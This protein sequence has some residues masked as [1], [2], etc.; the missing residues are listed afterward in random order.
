M[1]P[2]ERLTQ[3]MRRRM[4]ELRIKTWRQLAAHADISYETLRSARTGESVP[5]D[6]TKEGLERALR[7]QHGSIDAVLSGGDPT[8]VG[9]HRSGT[10]SIESKIRITGEGHKA[11][12]ADELD[13]LMEDP[14]AREAIRVLIER[15]R[16][17]H[18]APPLHSGDD[19]S[20]AKDDKAAG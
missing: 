3:A 13:K 20:S 16:A 8:P 2:H 11:E 10:A 4:A 18:G 19:E 9:D 17:L 14:E 1:E 6:G 7:W 12:P 5:S 15:S